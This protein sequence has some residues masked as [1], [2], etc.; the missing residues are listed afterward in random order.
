MSTGPRTRQILQAFKTVVSGIERVPGEARFKFVEIAGAV[1]AGLSM[2][3]EATMLPA[4]I[5]MEQGWRVVEEDNVEMMEHRVSVLIFQDI[6]MDRLRSQQLIGDDGIYALEDA[7]FDALSYKRVIDTE[8]VAYA[9]SSSA[10][11]R[12]DDVQRPY[13]TAA[14][15]L[16]EFVV[17][18]A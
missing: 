15:R 1:E 2:A 9:A 8:N 16:I 11:T 12:L 3:R 5:V 13:G 10:N 17:R 7:V 6:P 4:A 18:P 14:V